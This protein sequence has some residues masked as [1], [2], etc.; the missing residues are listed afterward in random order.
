M[1][2]KQTSQGT[3]MQGN[4]NTKRRQVNMF[5]ILRAVLDCGKKFTVTE[6][7]ILTKFILHG[8]PDP[9]AGI[10]YDIFPSVLKMAAQ[11]GCSD[12]A[13][14]GA[15]KKFN[16]LFMTTEEVHNHKHGGQSS[17]VCWI[18]IKKLTKFLSV[19]ILC[20]KTEPLQAIS[21][22]PPN[23][24]QGASEHGSDKQNKEQIRSTDQLVKNKQSFIKKIIENEE[25]VL[26]KL[27]ITNS[28]AES[29]L[30]YNQ[31][32][33][34][35]LYFQVAT[36]KPERFKSLQHAINGAVKLV[37]QGRFQKPFG[38][39]EFQQSNNNYN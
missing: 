16:G 19:D 28:L 13:I 29:K 2:T 25:P 22:T 9:E 18:D 39:E 21:E 30:E 37:A 15:R 32:L 8:K 23:T 14:Q 33:V 26:V 5:D 24:I 35:Q 38:Y 6:K 10:I 3:K 31:E 7:I 36:R 1:S 27:K 11:L 12:R 34:N 20:I 17:S 4:D